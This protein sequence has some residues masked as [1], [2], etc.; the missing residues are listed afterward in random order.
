MVASKILLGHV[1]VLLDLIVIRLPY[2][3]APEMQLS[4]IILKLIHMSISIA[5]AEEEED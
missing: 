5:V 3:L 4:Q 1:V 2:I